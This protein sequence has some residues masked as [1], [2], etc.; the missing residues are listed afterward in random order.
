LLLV[1]VGSLYLTSGLRFDFRE[2]FERMD[3]VRAW[4]LAPWKVFIATILPEVT[5]VTALLCVAIFARALLHGWLDPL[6]VLVVPAVAC[7][8]FLWVALDNAL[9]LFVP[10]RHVPG[11]DGGL[12]NTGRAMLMMMARLFLMGCTSLGA[13][14]PAL[15]L[16][17]LDNLFDLQID[18][19][20]M[21][22]AV[23]LFGALCVL[24]LEC[25]AAIWIGGV[26]LAR[27]DVARDRG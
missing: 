15:A 9:F 11:Q 27:F 6:I 22:W 7:F 4:P 1:A 12:Q 18:R 8:V 16:I 17:L 2:D 19:G 25:V 3:V 20:Q 21:L 26:A 10:V 14:L 24:A 13:A 23:A 5:L